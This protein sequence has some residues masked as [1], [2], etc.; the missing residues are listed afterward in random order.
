MPYRKHLNKDK[1]LKAVIKQQE[2]HTLE[3]RKNMCLHICAS[4]MSQQLS[5]KVAAVIY[6]RFLNLFKSKNP[7]PAVILDVSHEQLRSIGLSNSKAVYIKNVCQFF[8]EHKLTDAKLYKLSNEE[9]IELLTQIKG[10]GKW[11][12]EMILMFALGRE[13]V[14][15][16]GDFGIQKAM[17]QLY[18]IQYTNQKDLIEQMIAISNKWSPYRSYACKHLWRY[19]DVPLIPV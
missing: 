17:I 19:L 14:F 11:T 18:H 3:V 12:V 16:T 5:T 8:I 7:K 2:S 10:V 9:L 6:A 13:D 1:I 4:I 15:S